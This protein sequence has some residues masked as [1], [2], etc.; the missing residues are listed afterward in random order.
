MRIR[1]VKASNIFI[2]KE[3]ESST[4]HL[5]LDLLYAMGK[6][7][8]FVQKTEIYKML[9]VT[10]RNQ[11]EIGTMSQKNEVLFLHLCRI[12][13]QYHHVNDIASKVGQVAKQHLEGAIGIINFCGIIQ[14]QTDMDIVQG[15]NTFST[16]FEFYETIF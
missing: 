11:I 12:Y 10:D 8:L 7:D 15:Y 6:Y 3:L 9:L 13:H 16:S 5:Y 4:V 1:L 14:T 2:E